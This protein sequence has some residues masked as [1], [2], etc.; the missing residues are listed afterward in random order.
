MDRRIIFSLTVL[1][2]AV[3]LFI[4]IQVFDVFEDSEVDEPQV[5]E[6]SQSVLETRSLL[7]E[8]LE[9]D[10]EEGDEEEIV[11]IVLDLGEVEESAVESI[12]DK[13]NVNVLG[14]YNIFDRIHIDIKAPLGQIEEIIEELDAE[15]AEYTPEPEPTMDTSVPQIQADQIKDEGYDGSGVT[16]AILDTGVR[17]GH[18]ALED[19]IHSHHDF[20][21]NP[22]Y[23]PGE[24]NWVHGTLTAGVITGDGSVGEPGVAPG[25]EIIDLKVL[26]PLDTD[27]YDPDDYEHCSEDDERPEGGRCSNP[28]GAY[29]Y[30]SD[31]T[32]QIDIVS[33]SMSNTC[34]N[35]GEDLHS[36]QAEQIMEE[37]IVYVNSA[38]NDGTEP[39]NVAGGAC[40]PDTIAVGNIEPG[41]TNLRSSSQRGDPDRS[42][43]ETKP[44]ITAPGSRVDNVPHPSSPTAT[45][46]YGGTSA[47]APHVSAGIALL[48]ESEGISGPANAKETIQDSAAA[49]NEYE[50]HEVGAGLLQLE[51]EDEDLQVTDVQVNY[52]HETF[53]GA[54]CEE[55]ERDAV[56]IEVCGDTASLTESQGTENWEYADPE[57]VVPTDGSITDGKILKCSPGTHGPI[58]VE[59]GNPPQE[60]IGFDGEI[61]VNYNTEASTWRVDRFDADSPLSEEDGLHIHRLEESFP[62]EIHFRE[63]NCADRLQ[64]SD[65]DVAHPV[66]T[67]VVISESGSAPHY[68]T[69][70]NDALKE[71]YQ[72]PECGGYIE[73][74]S[75]CQVA[76][77][78]FTTYE[79]NCEGRCPI[80]HKEAGEDSDYLLRGEMIAG[81]EF[82]PQD[83]TWPQDIG[84]PRDETRFHI[85][86]TEAPNSEEGKY[87][88]SPGDHWNTDYFVCDGGDWEPVEE[89][90]P[91]YT[92][93]DQECE[94]DTVQLDVEFYELEGVS[95]IENSFSVGF[96]IPEQ[97][98][99]KFGDV[100]GDVPTEINAQCWHGAE[101]QRPNDESYID[102]VAAI[103]TEIV[104]G[105][106]HVTATV[107]SR[108]E[109][110]IETDKY[111]CV[112]TI[113]HTTLEGEGVHLG[114]NNPCLEDCMEPL[115]TVNTEKTPFHRNDL[116]SDIG[117]QDPW[118]DFQDYRDRDP[119]GNLY[120]HW[121]MRDYR[122]QYGSPPWPP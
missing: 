52:N 95:D 14:T 22:Q 34:D 78:E 60:L 48:M 122:N 2:V 75:A 58:A 84:L 65:C 15:R 92:H 109:Y 1:L 93:I 73:T 85:C 91:G 25:A 74:K 105:D 20:T 49:L 120:N 36:V 114:S 118:N 110:D 12:R 50:P 59:D 102:N 68:A 103:S 53:I 80:G 17:E 40:H 43:G 63:G 3:S 98:I 90:P 5:P 97:E 57:I 62:G 61:E 94:P 86:E 9:R 112:F 28:L 96:R 18:E 47:A 56:L 71:D 79:S 6:E 23:G 107:P 88:F 31:N 89:C 117:A 99:E 33:R 69:N 38:G 106:A 119:D 115:I 30:I 42:D 81:K 39:D 100:Y 67:G 55:C 66:Q 26:S 54:N 108:I 45:S 82:N 21:D 44:D 41:T 10:L 104:D 72:Y 27:Q 7:S 116:P 11:N 70:I 51:E 113:E 46:D 77:Q 37:G 76:H 121:P 16:I 4:G 8:E 13:E 101:R 87:V 35:E 32:D 24:D 111:S 64:D 83:E 29:E 19:S